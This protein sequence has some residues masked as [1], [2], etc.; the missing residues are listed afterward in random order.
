MTFGVGVIGRLAPTR[1]HALAERL[2]C[3]DRRRGLREDLGTGSDRRSHAQCMS[4]RL[5]SLALPSVDC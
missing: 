2:A 5:P 1:G 3:P 4:T